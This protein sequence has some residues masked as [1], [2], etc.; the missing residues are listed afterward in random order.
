MVFPRLDPGSTV[1]VD[2]GKPC[3][4]R[5]P[6]KGGMF[7]CEDDVW[8]GGV[9]REKVVCRLLAGV[10]VSGN[11]AGKDGGAGKKRREEEI[12][13]TDINALMK[14]LFDSA[15]VK[16]DS[17][18]ALWNEDT[19][20]KQ[21]PR[22]YSSSNGRA[23]EELKRLI[24]AMVLTKRVG[25][26]VPVVEYDTFVA[27]GPFN[28]HTDDYDFSRDGEDGGDAGDKVMMVE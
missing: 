12:F 4:E 1:L 6:V 22:I 16:G 27:L 9:E 20:R 18:V 23:A 8:R 13:M 15:D 25:N 24:A 14:N 19:A 7:R 28:G 3:T 17:V 2:P 5:K 10:G 11:L 26:L 21:Y